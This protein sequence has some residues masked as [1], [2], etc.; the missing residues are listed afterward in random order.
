M[1]YFIIKLPLKYFLPIFLL[2]FSFLSVAYIEIPATQTTNQNI[3]PMAE[4]KNAYPSD[5]QTS[6]IVDNGSH[7]LF[8]GGTG[9]S[10]DASSNIMAISFDSL[11]RLS[12]TQSQ[13]TDIFTK[14]GEMPYN[15]YG[16][17]LVRDGSNV[18]FF[19]GVDVGTQVKTILKL[20]ISQYPYQFT[21]VQNLT[22]GLENP[23]LIRAGQL[24]Y[25]FG[26]ANALVGPQREVYAFNLTDN[27]LKDLNIKSPV[28]MPTVKIFDN[29]I[30]LIGGSDPQ[31]S[32]YSQAVYNFNPQT[33]EFSKVFNAP[34]YTDI[35]NAFL[36][37][38]KLIIINRFNST[39]FFNNLAVFDFFS[40]GRS[41]YN[42]P[43]L[44]DYSLCQSFQSYV[45]ND[46]SLYLFGGIVPRT[47]N[48]THDI[49][50][51]NL[52]KIF[53]S[54]S[55]VNGLSDSGSDIISNNSAILATDNAVNYNFGDTLSSYTKPIDEI[56]LNTNDS[57][58]IVS[59]YLA[60]NDPNS[61]QRVEIGFT[62]GVPTEPVDFYNT[63]PSE[64]FIGIQIQNVFTNN[65]NYVSIGA[66]VV[67]NNVSLLGNRVLYNASM[68]HTILF[69]FTKLNETAFYYNLGV[70]QT[71]IGGIISG[72][73]NN[74]KLSSFSVWNE[75]NSFLTLEGSYKGEV[76]SASFIHEVIPQSN[77]NLKELL[78]I[79]LFLN[80]F[81]ILVLIYII[82]A[83]RFKYIAT[84]TKPEGIPSSLVNLGFYNLYISLKKAFEKLDK[85]AVVNLEDDTREFDEAFKPKIDFL[86][87]SDDIF[88][89]E[90]GLE[91]ITG[92]AMRILIHLLDY[93]DHGTYLTN[94]QVSLDI[95]RSSF[96]YTINKLK[97][98]GFI[99]YKLG[100]NED[101]RKKYVVISPK[102]YNLLKLVYKHLNSYFNSSK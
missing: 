23:Q 49:F 82:R 84:G 26:G 25:I 6:A 58:T 68:P 83:P 69:R 45:T 41:D 64:N 28:Y 78:G 40:Q 4:Y 12:T 34:F 11:N 60:H 94:V 52:T 93:L 88:T 2:T 9:D 46:M 30:Y 27:S 100:L 8:F 98:K 3:L 101:Q 35:H 24:V 67:N 63:I 18:Y 19:G 10:W 55:I 76:N 54:D 99:D 61:R 57:L 42:L 47:I 37:N 77:Q 65:Q 87:V 90:L 1:G 5:L 21:V 66:Y 43:S 29:S 44:P 73:L 53:G 14:V 71:K 56:N 97:D 102:G 85:L 20:D 86:K 95:S 17:G 92:L 15:V 38:N 48:R 31:T 72:N 32:A 13:T 70:D 75:N 22:N 50:K 96:Y 51:I 62:S 16:M 79:I 91:D 81:L 80:L 89:D 59:T 39:S 33:N 74:F 7:I 36:L